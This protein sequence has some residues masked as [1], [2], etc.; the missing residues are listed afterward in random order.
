MVSRL[1]LVFFA[2][3]LGACPCGDGRPRALYDGFE[4]ERCAEVPCGWDVV[5]GEVTPTVTLHPAEHGLRLAAGAALTHALDGPELGDGDAAV[6]LL[7]RCEAGTAVRV[8]LVLGADLHQLS[9]LSDAPTR[10]APR[11]VSLAQP[12]VDEA[13]QATGGAPVEVQIELVGPGRCD[14]DELTVFSGPPFF[15]D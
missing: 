10:D 14:I 11:F 1:V 15:C 7:L 8:T 6:E 2:L 3:A 12:L 9:A 5:A 13:G 4:D